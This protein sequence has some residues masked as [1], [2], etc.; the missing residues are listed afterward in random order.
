MYIAFEEG[1]GAFGRSGNQNK[2]R[3]VVK[4]QR[5][6][7]ANQYFEHNFLSAN[8]IDARPFGFETRLQDGS[9]ELLQAS[10]G[11]RSQTLWPVKVR[12]E[13]CQKGV[14][15]R[16]KIITARELNL[17]RLGII[18]TLRQNLRTIFPP[19]TPL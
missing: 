15:P 9:N 8:D 19:G 6:M 2:K 10:I 1:K 17:S 11:V 7:I 13:I 12:A 14:P 18:F 16:N 4:Q 5:K 3:E